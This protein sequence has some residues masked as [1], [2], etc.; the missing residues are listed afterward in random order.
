MVWVQ[1]DPVKPTAEG[2]ARGLPT[3]T[4]WPVL[5]SRIELKTTTEKYEPKGPQWATASTSS[6]NGNGNDNTNG[7]NGD[8]KPS[9]SVQP[10]NTRLVHYYQYH[11]RALGFFDPRDELQADAKE[12]LP[13]LVGSELMGGEE[14]WGKLG[15]ETHAS[16][17]AEVTREAEADAK[18]P[19]GERGKMTVDQRWQKTSWV[20]R[21]GFSAMPRDWDSVVVRAGLAIKMALVSVSLCWIA[22]R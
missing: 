21:I 9:S 22:M 16:I 1:I 8:G 4:H 14:G 15:E 6:A 17:E 10:P 18:L 2:Q 12:L 7:A 11:L 3:I 5:C 20:N 19:V 13:W